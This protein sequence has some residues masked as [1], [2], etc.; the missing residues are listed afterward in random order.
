MPPTDRIIAGAKYMGLGFEFAGIIVAAVIGGYYLDDYLG[1]TPLFMLLLTAGGM[2]GA[3]KRL[4][5]TLKKTR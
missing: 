4:L 5:W 1:T 2:F 3:I